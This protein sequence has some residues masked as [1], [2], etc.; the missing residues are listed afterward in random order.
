MNSATEYAY[1]IVANAISRTFSPVSTKTNSNIAIVQD[2]LVLIVEVALALSR[3]EERN[4][5]GHIA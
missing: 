2:Q 5:Q 3:E 4:V 1:N